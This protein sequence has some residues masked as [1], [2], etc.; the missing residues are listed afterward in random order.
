MKRF[1]LAWLTLLWG[2]AAFAADL[3]QPP[4]TYKTP[5]ASPADLFTGWWLIG[6]AG[7]GQG[8]LDPAPAGI[9]NIKPEGFIGG[10]GIQS[11]AKVA[12][13]VYLGLA[14]SIDFGDMNGSIHPG[15]GL[16]VTGKHDWLG[17]TT[18]S[19]GYL[20]LPNLL[21]YV[22]G[23]VAY[24]NTKASITAG[25]FA[26]H[27]AQTSV[28]WTLGGGVDY[29]IAQW[30]PNAT[31]GFEYAY[32]DLGSSAYC[33]PAGPACIGVKAKDSDNLFL[34]NFKYRFGL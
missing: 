30:L 31:L 7:Y 11:R 3:P 22:D 17:R 18:L 12:P 26:T 23:G 33:F 21:A 34:A 13:N 15:G 5:A 8:T 27:T 29:S 9:A 28:G 19:L 2:S 4:P 32:V 25:G 14:S 10:V 16:T 24:G 20:V 6:E 1:T